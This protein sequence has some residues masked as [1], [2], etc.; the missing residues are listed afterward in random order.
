MITIGDK[1][2]HP[3]MPDWGLGKVMEVTSDGKA[4]IFFQN[5]LQGLCFTRQPFSD[6]IGNTVDIAV[7]K[8]FF[9]LPG[10]FLRLFVRQSQRLRHRIQNQKTD[11]LITMIGSRWCRSATDRLP[12]DRC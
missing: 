11:T 4:R 8:L 3:K 2:R 9:D 1:V 6:N 10:E 5:L 12:S 7:P